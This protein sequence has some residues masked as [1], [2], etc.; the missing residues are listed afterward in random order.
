VVVLLLP[1][2]KPVISLCN[3][4]DFRGSTLCSGIMGRVIRREGGVQE[5]LLSLTFLY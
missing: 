5:N 4:F 3:A 1:S 2:A